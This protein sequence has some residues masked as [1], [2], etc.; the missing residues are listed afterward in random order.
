MQE[1]KFLPEKVVLES[2]QQLYKKM[3]ESL[4]LSKLGSLE[5]SSLQTPSEALSIAKQIIH[6]DEQPM[7]V[8]GTNIVFSKLHAFL[9]SIF[10]DPDIEIKQIEL[11]ELYM[12][13]EKIGVPRK[14]DGTFL[15]F[16][17]MS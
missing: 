10:S 5:D 4:S 11:E 2:S 17:D 9:A 13:L 14:E 1:R 7:I 3:K 6:Q 15:G 16:R 8:S 12:Y